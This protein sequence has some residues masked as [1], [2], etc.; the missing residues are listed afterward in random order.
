M[1]VIMKSKLDPYGLEIASI[2]KFGSYSLSHQNEELAV[3]SIKWIGLK[4]SRFIEYGIPNKCM[5]EMTK[6][7]VK[8]AKNL[9]KRE[10]EDFK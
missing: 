6:M 4:I 3:P 10:I 7:D 2:Y 1:L 8:K 5:I 9:Y